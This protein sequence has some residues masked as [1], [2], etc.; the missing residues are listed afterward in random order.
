MGLLFSYCYREIEFCILYQNMLY[1]IFKVLFSKDGSFYIIPLGSNQKDIFGIITKCRMK[2]DERSD[3][4]LIN[5]TSK[6]NK[7]ITSLPKLSFHPE[8]NSQDAVCQFSGS[9]KVD[10]SVQLRFNNFRDLTNRLASLQIQS[11][12]FFDT[13]SLDKAFDNNKNFKRITL[14]SSHNKQ[15]SI[16]FNFYR[17]PINLYNKRKGSIGP[18]FIEEKYPEIKTYTYLRPP[19]DYV[20]H[21]FVI[22]I[23]TEYFESREEEHF[24]MFS[25]ISNISANKKEEMF[26]DVLISHFPAKISNLTSKMESLDIINGIRPTITNNLPIDS[27]AA[28]YEKDHVVLFDNP[29]DKE[30]FG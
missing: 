18:V 26:F 24:D 11:F 3:W 23:E 6:N 2:F 8:T 20:Y 21:D 30:L 12:W 5:L 14:R 9:K 4:R 19:I 10:N 27:Y 1:R 13:I 25:N 28:K 17:L 29:T 7:T 15:N 16:R 22:V